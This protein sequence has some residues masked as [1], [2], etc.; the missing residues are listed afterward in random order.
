[1]GDDIVAVAALFFGGPTAWSRLLLLTGLV[2]ALVNGFRFLVGRPKAAMAADGAPPAPRPEG[3]TAFLRGPDAAI[4]TPPALVLLG[5]CVGVFRLTPW[6]LLCAAPPAALVVIAVR[7]LR[8]EHGRRGEDVVAGP[9]LAVVLVTATL[10][11]LGVVLTVRLVVAPDPEVGFKPSFT[12]GSLTEVAMSVGVPLAVLVALLF[13]ERLP[14]AVRERVGKRRPTTLYALGVA[15]VAALFLAPLVDP[16]GSSDKLT[17][18]R[19]ATAEYGKVLYVWVLSVVLARYAIGFQVR[20]G[21]LFAHPGTWSVERTRRALGK[22]KHVAYTFLLFGLVGVAGLV[23]GDIGPTIPL[24]LAT[25]AIVVFLLRLQVRSGAR[26]V[27]TLDASRSLW[28]ALGLVGLVALGVLQLDYVRTRQDAWRDPWSFNWSSGCTAPPEGVRP[29]QDVP[30]GWVACLKSLDADAAGKRSQV[31]QSMAAI[32]DGGAWGRGLADT[33]VGH[34]PAGSTDFV[35]AVLWNKLGGLAV[36]LV[37]LLLALL[38]AALARVRAHLERFREARAEHLGGAAERQARAARLFAVGVAG[39]LLGQHLFVFL[40][41]L[42]VLPHSGITAPLLSRGGQSTLALA[43][44]V[45][46]AVWLLYRADRPLA[47]VPPAAARARAD[48][49][50]AL[51]GVRFPRTRRVVPLAFGAVAV[52]AALFATT[53]TIAPYGRLPESRRFCLTQ[54]A[55]VDPERCST[56]RTANRRTSVELRAGGQVLYTRDRARQEWVADGTPPLSLSDLAG[57]IRLDGHGGTL[58][59]SLDGLIDGGSGT[60]LRE[61]VLPSVDGPEPGYLD[62]TVVPRL[63]RAMTGALRSDA[64]GGGPLAGGLVVMDAGTGHVLAASSAPSALDWPGQPEVEQGGSEDFTA[65]HPHYGTIENGVVDESGQGCES[66]DWDER[67]WRWSLD[68]RPATPNPAALA[69]RERYAPGTPDE[70]LPSLDENRALERRYGLGSTFKV[71]VA[72]AFL[73]Q[74]GRTARSL[75]PSPAR[76]TPPHGK[77]IENHERGA[78]CAGTVDGAITLKQALTVSCN[79]AFVAAAL[80]LGWPAIRDT[81][82]ELGF[83]D[84]TAR[85]T[86][87]AWLAGPPAGVASHVPPAVDVEGMDSLG[88]NTLGGGRV[89][90]T[91]LALATA[92]TAVANGGRVVQP[93]IVAETCDPLGRDRRAYAGEQRQV[94]TPAQARELDD[95]LSGVAEDDNGTAHRLEAQPN[96]ALRV[97][98]GTHEIHGEEETPPDGRFAKQ[99]AWVVGALRTAAG[100]VT[101][102]VAVETRDEGAGSR[103]AQ[104]L[105]QQVIDEVVE[106]RG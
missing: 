63:Q 57:L 3:P 91:P 44:A 40:A 45:L 99:V 21:R 13:A 68:P 73:K 105:A 26:L 82:I 34:V 28:L 59:T 8:A 61:R 77:P 1:M 60:S 80:E 15:G 106:V 11:L 74:P 18:L 64:E 52:V 38:A 87:D 89:E 23:K 100:P 42:N 103:R 5:A 2:L 12:T 104:W 79:T 51:T 50:P 27:D 84:P 78:P 102:A 46:I 66:T 56:D 92:M 65:N 58:N 85:G 29:P 94:L 17:F 54:E 19:F 86:D 22:S 67:C 81:A 47:P 83:T 101:F 93:T 20:P 96:R 62:L 53:I 55:R 70:V 6:F 95:A 10:V 16:L 43:G 41:T 90:G 36:V 25:V 24:F 97:K 48:R 33:R 35:L 4:W 75:L 9:A 49:A 37:T 14:D 98:T 88:N 76:I 71:V 30:P 7:R 31:A 72:A 39:M 32:A 69:E